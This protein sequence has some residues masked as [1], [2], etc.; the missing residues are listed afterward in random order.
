MK[1]LNRKICSHSAR[2]FTLI[3]VLMVVMIIAI[4]AVLAIPMISSGADFQLR[5]AANIIAADLEYAK[6]LA[7]TNQDN[8]SIIFDA[9]NESYEMHDSNG[10]IVDDPVRPSGGIA[11]DFANDSRFSQVDIETVSFD[12]TDTV[13][14]D[15]LGAPYNG[16]FDLLSSSAIVVKAGN[17]TI[18][19]TVAPVTGYITIE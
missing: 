1:L 4:G 2:A 7:I 12:S 3:E 15:Y 6:S 5:A 14:F 13:I 17:Q 19:V 9:G 11:V 18:T 16:S 10:E 8:Y